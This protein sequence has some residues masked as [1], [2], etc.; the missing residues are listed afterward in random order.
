MN[1]S[2]KCIGYKYKTFRKYCSFCGFSFAAR[3]RKYLINY[4]DKFATDV[5]CSKDC[6]DKALWMAKSI[7]RSMEGKMTKEELEELSK[8]VENVA[9]GL[10]VLEIT[11][12]HKNCSFGDFIIEEKENE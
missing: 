1:Q 10:S 4:G 7:R 5:V 2:P 3:T 6:R 9:I 8:G 12:G 11:S